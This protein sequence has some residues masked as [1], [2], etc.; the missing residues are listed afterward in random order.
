MSKVNILVLGGTGMLGHKMFLTPAFAT[1]AALSGRLTA[2]RSTPLT[3]NLFEDFNL[4]KESS[5]TERVKSAK[6]QGPRSLVLPVEG[7]NIPCVDVALQDGDAVIVERLDQALITVVGLVNKPGTF[8]YPPGTQYNLINVLGLAGGLNQVAKPRY[9]T[10]YRKKHDHA[11]AK[12]RFRLVDGS[13]MTDALNVIIK[14]GDIVAVEQ[15][16]RTRTNVILNRI[17]RLNLGG[18]V[19]LGAL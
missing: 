19:P 11:I 8:P 17:F 14:P 10:I 7:L 16:P 18:Y 1:N 5:A 9:A 4:A 15:T 13:K 2:G 6:P 12:A 3:S